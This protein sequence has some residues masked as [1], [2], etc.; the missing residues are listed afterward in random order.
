MVTQG[1]ILGHVISTSGIEVDPAKVELIQKLPIPR[2]VKDV[3]SFL[4]YAGF[5]MR[6]IKS[7]SPIFRPLCALLA[8]DAPSEWTPSCQLAFEKL[9]DHLITA[10]IIQPSDWSLPFELMYDAS[11]N[12]VG[13]VLG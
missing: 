4:G 7:F 2:Y 6:F 11:D 8:K 3:R 9:K 1:I 12:V 10:P 13:A 5:Y